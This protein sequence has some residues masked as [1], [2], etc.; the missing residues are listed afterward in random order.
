MS[1]HAFL[2]LIER[3]RAGD[4]DSATLLVKRYEV[5]VRRAVRF[6]LTDLRM[7]SLFDSMDICQSAMGSFFA[8]AAAGQYEVNSP[9][10]L[11]KLLTRIAR[12]KLVNHIRKDHAGLSL[13]EPAATQAAELSMAVSAEPDPARFSMIFELCQ[14]ALKR[15]TSEE[16]T[17]LEHRRQGH[18][19]EAVAEIMQ[20]SPVA[21]R[22]QLSRALDRVLREVELE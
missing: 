17:L 4:Q 12:N 20:S 6:R 16:R 22:K 11:V 3:V 15:M 1:D 13:R 14:S 7:R 18:A 21:L 8:R 2:S 19:W 10:D 5:A 9:E